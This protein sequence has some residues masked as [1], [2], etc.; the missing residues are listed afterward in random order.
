MAF[1]ANQLAGCI[2]SIR[3]FAVLIGKSASSTTKR[4]Q[5]ERR[6]EMRTFH[7]RLFMVISGA[8]I[9]LGLTF[10]FG[11]KTVKDADHN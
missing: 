4:I 1:P 5:H 7:N 10:G 11:G 2:G 8:L 3:K 9:V 6:R